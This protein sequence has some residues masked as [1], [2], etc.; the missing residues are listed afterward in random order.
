MT[1]QEIRNAI[2][3]GTHRAI[4]YGIKRQRRRYVVQKF[5]PQ[6]GWLDVSAHGNAVR[7][8]IKGLPSRHDMVCGLVYDSA[9]LVGL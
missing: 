3:A 6:H 1:S 5:H 7:L 9:S 2:V 4:T 8:A